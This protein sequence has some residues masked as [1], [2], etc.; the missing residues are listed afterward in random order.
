MQ[1][2][3]ALSRVQCPVFAGGV[4]RD[5]NVT[6]LR[7]LVVADF[8]D[9]AGGSHQ[10]YRNPSIFLFVFRKPSWSTPSESCHPSRIS[11]GRPALSLSTATRSF[12]IEVKEK[13]EN[14]PHLGRWSSHLIPLE[15][16]PPLNLHGDPLPLA[17]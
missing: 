11:P 7:R 15:K 13:V 9:V 5:S 17:A 2:V 16:S 6:R 4:L 8:A 10:T 12:P 1:F 3:H 14:N